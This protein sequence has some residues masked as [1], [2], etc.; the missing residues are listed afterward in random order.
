MKIFGEGQYELEAENGE[1]IQLDLKK[2]KALVII[3]EK[4]DKEKDDSSWF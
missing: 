1:K 4:K 2:D 3:E